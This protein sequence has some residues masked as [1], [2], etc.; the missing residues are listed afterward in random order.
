MTAIASLCHMR[1][2]L[3]SY[4]KREKQIYRISH[5]AVWNVPARAYTTAAKNARLLQNCKQ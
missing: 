1:T 5:P 4:I 3:F 2:D